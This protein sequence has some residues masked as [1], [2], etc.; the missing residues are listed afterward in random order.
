MIPVW[1]PGLVFLLAGSLL[2]LGTAYIFDR[3]DGGR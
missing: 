3:M 2:V 1:A